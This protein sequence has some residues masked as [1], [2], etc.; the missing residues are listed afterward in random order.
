MPGVGR[1]LAVRMVRS[2]KHFVSPQQ[3][4][5]E[6]PTLELAGGV[7]SQTWQKKLLHGWMSGQ[8]SQTWLL[9]EHLT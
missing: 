9:R 7:L 8:L 6:T 2:S 4:L 5:T 3:S 1:T